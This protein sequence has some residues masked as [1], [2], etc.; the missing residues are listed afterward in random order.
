MAPCRNLSSPD[1]IPRWSIER[2]AGQWYGREGRRG[3]DA[4]TRRTVSTSSIDCVRTSASS[5]ILF[6]TSL[7]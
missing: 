2:N 4:Q 7:I 5:L 3:G 6:V 1:V